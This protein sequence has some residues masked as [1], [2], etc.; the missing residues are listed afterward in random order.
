MR[1]TNAA[2]AMCALL[3][4]LSSCVPIPGSGWQA[5]PGPDGS[6]RTASSL[7]EAQ[8][9]GA[10]GGGDPT[11]CADPRTGPLAGQTLEIVR[12]DAAS[13]AA[14]PHVIRLE[15]SDMVA[16]ALGG[17][18]PPTSGRCVR[19]IVVVSSADAAL[20]ALAGARAVIEGV[21]LV[22]ASDAPSDGETGAASDPGAQLGALVERLV[23]FGVEELAVH[24]PSPQW[25][26]RWTEDWAGDRA[27]E[28][29]GA[30]RRRVIE[31]VAA[32]SDVLEL[33]LTLTLSGARE[34]RHGIVLVPEDDV[35]AQVE[36]VARAADGPVPV[37]VPRD[38][39]RAAALLHTVAAL[40]ADL[41]VSWAASTPQ[42]ARM[43]APALG[44]LRS[45]R[46]PIDG[47]HRGTVDEARPDV[48]PELWLGDVRDADGALAAAVLAS[49]RRAVFVAV[50]GADLRRVP[51]RTERMR[52]AHSGS[53]ARPDATVEVVLVGAV[54]RHTAWQL[55]TVLTGTTTAA[56][57]GLLPLEDRRIVALYGSPEAPSLG[58]LGEQ[59]APATIA[60]AV[61][62]ADRYADA[63]D[64]RTA[65]PGLDIIATVASSAAEP[66][67][68]Y[69]RR[70]PISRLR[71]L[72][73]QA[74]DAGVA[75][76][77]DLQPGRTS[78]LT[79]AQEYEK[80]LRE[81]HVHLALDPEWR[82]GPRERHLLR[83]GSVE[84]SEV[85]DVADWLA[86][87]VRRERLPQKVLMLHQFTLAMLPDRD[88]IV[89]PDEL[90]G[91]VHID[92]QGPLP[93]KDRTYAV[94]TQGAEERWAWG[95]KNFTRIDVPV[96]TPEQSLDRV[97]V[98][99]VITYQ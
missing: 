19:R 18:S 15:S 36:A 45:A 95:W 11:A 6:E 14:V 46:R 72:V 49:A 32:G 79:Q 24:G 59:D 91:V 94:L 58:L 76:F 9:A 62:V 92:G 5:S 13:G 44:G 81:P 86:G 25:A 61:E 30:D 41:P 17:T 42:Y 27:S 69:S 43:L 33:A 98:P 28:W 99:L 71:P 3:L 38:E 29:A 88:T 96:A 52:D 77:L 53:D 65:V 16:A 20:R 47:A 97:P 37:V 68:D 35:A 90:V 63:A 2:V 23:Q 74:R 64:G 80:L 51:E 87:L 1:R 26:V 75:V 7:P 57:G 89:V 60:R 4:V 83:I 8:D 48:R 55:D 31:S 40:D 12:S 50:D 82:I 73:D 84:A 54:E 10:G 22:I 66:T 70:V 21:P 34:D 39:R 93:L 78:F 67:D 56:G 85:Q